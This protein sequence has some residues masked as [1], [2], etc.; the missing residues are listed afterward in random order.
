[1][2][3][4]YGGRKPT[5]AEATKRP[6]ARGRFAVTCLFV[7]PPACSARVPGRLGQKGPLKCWTH[8]QTARGA[9]GQGWPPR[10]TGLPAEKGCA[11]HFARPGCEAESPRG[12]AEGA[13]APLCPQHSTAE[14]APGGA[15][16]SAVGVSVPSSKRRGG[17]DGCW[18]DLAFRLPVR[19]DLKRGSAFRISLSNGLSPGLFVVSSDLFFKIFCPKHRF[20]FLTAKVPQAQ[21]ARLGD[22]RKECRGLTSVGPPAPRPGAGRRGNPCRLPESHT[23]ENV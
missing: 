6:V 20:F 12:G 7:A 1:M 16:P 3:I 19:A 18:R 11:Q 9:L 21:G 13:Q 10:V 15:H 4:S 22:H 14:G 5:R 2:G 17:C 23:S 8:H